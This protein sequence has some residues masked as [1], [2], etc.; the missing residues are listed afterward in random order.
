MKT[1][2]PPPPSPA[3][4]PAG[5]GPPIYNPSQLRL[6]TQALINLILDKDMFKSAMSD[7]KLD[8]SVSSNFLNVFLHDSLP[9]APVI[10]N[11]TS[12]LSL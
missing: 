11:F 6:E 7:L 5:K 1:A 10:P 8:M 2:G 4:S 12:F 3:R 9:S